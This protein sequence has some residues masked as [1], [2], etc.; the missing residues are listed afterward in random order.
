MCILTEN[1]QTLCPPNTEERW[2]PENKRP[3]ALS[4]ILRFTGLDS[5]KEITRTYKLQLQLLPH[6]LNR[7]AVMC[8]PLKA[9]Q[10]E[11]V[12]G[13]SRTRARAT[14]TMRDA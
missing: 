7:K 10:Y 1:R 5:L 14:A 11:A 12:H 3:R 13:L 4:I 8:L 2:R 9:V 6:V